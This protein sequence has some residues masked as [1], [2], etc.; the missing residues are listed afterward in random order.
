[1]AKDVVARG[2]GKAG[3]GNRLLESRCRKDS[4]RWCARYWAVLS[5]SVPAEEGREEL[6]EERGE[7]CLQGVKV[8]I[9]NPDALAAAVCPGNDLHPAHG[10]PQ[11]IGQQA[12]ARDVGLPLDGR[13]ADGDLEGPLPDPEDRILLGPGLDEDGQDEISPAGVEV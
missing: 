11:D 6:F 7:G 12:P 2:L 8:G 9:A 5:G 3:F 1:M 10:N 4:C 13:S